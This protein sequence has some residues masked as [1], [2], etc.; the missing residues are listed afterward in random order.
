MKGKAVARLDTV[1]FSKNLGSYQLVHIE[2]NNLPLFGKKCLSH[3]NPGC[4][5]SM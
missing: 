1:H 2:K 4:D 5:T 3:Y